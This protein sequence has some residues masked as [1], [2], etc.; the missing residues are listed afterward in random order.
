MPLIFNRAL[1]DVTSRTQQ[2]AGLSIVRFKPKFLTGHLAKKRDCPVKNWTQLLEVC[3]G[4]AYH[5][6]DHNSQ[7]AG[8]GLKLGPAQ[9]SRY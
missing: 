1:N 6:I 7:P 8:P 5:F 9:N 4:R 2:K 3:T